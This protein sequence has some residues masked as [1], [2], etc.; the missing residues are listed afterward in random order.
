MTLVLFA[1]GTAQ[2]GLG[3]YRDPL[4][5]VDVSGVPFRFELAS[6][7]GWP[8]AAAPANGGTVPNLTGGTAG[9]VVIASGQTVAYSGG[10]FDFT[11]LTGD[12]GE[13]L[14]PAGSLTAI[15]DA[16]QYFMVMFY[17]KLPASGDYNSDAVISPMFETTGNANGYT[18]ANDML[19]IAQVTGGLLA[20]RRQTN[21]S[22]VD[23]INLSAAAHYGRVC[24]IAYWRNAA[25]QGFRIKSA[26]G[27]TTGTAAV[28][29]NNAGSFAAARPRWGV[30][31]AFNNPADAQHQAAF[32]WRLYGGMVENLALT[33]RN[34]QTVLDADWTRTV[35]RNAYS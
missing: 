23:A 1:S 5:P 3:N 9:E 31:I 8:S 19:T 6:G 21:G 24:Q 18:A 26:G 16:S 28:G 12:P 22:T 29:S 15:N 32:K 13:V 33:G 34:P 20:A 27:T 2:R 7:L 25:G 17:A 4:L 30:P 11:G 35:S 10:G 14:G